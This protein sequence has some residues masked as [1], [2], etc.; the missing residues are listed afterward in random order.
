M[1]VRQMTSAVLNIK[2]LFVPVNWL[3]Q[4]W[5]RRSSYFLQQ[6]QDYC[7]KFGLISLVKVYLHYR[8]SHRRCSVRKGTLSNFAKFTEKHL[9]Q[10]HFLLK[11][12]PQASNF[13]KKRL[14]HRC[15]LMDL[16]KFLRTPFFI[17]HR[18]ANASGIRR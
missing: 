12:Q 18:W 10:G 3:W 16:T 17:E 1:K 11:L 14:R 8:S 5:S 15:F 6:S 2:I 4:P 7:F 13:V 9:C